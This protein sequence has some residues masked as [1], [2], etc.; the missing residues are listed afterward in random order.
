MERNYLLT[1][2]LACFALLYTGE[3]SAVAQGKQKLAVLP[4]RVYEIDSISTRT[5]L[6]LLRQELEKQGVYSIV[7]ESLTPQN[8]CQDVPCAIEAGAGVNADKVVFGNFSKLGTKILW[9]YTLVDVNGKSKVFTGDITRWKIEDFADVVLI[10]AKSIESGM[11]EPEIASS[12]KILPSGPINRDRD[13]VSVGVG[14]G[15]MYPTHGYY[16]TSVFS[17]DTVK[18]AFILDCRLGLER[19]NYTLDLLVALREGILVNIGA[20]YVPFNSVI[21]PYIGGG[22]GYHAQVNGFLD[23]DEGDS[24]FF[25]SGFQCMVKGGIWV[26]RTSSLRAFINAD[27]MY[28]FN[29]RDDQA[30]SLTLGVV[31]IN[32]SFDF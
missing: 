7:E 23:E 19:P 20:S 31:G 18:R 5:L 8:P 15:Q 17:P 25:T 11:V 22:V 2:I 13:T 4:F 26:L 9:T 14:I 6:S 27:Y 30:V 10:V 32:D 1:A 28:T 24:D 29:S 21:A 12:T 16:S 3:Q